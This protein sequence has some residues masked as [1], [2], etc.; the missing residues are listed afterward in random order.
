MAAKQKA[1]GTARGGLR[2]LEQMGLRD[3]E[4]L[5]LVLRGESVVD[6]RR[7][8]FETREQV[9]AFLAI[10]L[11]ELSNVRDEQRVRSILA[12]AV[13]YLRTVFGYRVASAVANPEDLRDL[14][15]FASGVLEPRKYRRIACVVL[16]VMHV[17]QHLEAREL[18][19]RTP[20]REVDL[21]EKVDRRVI[22]ELA[23]LQEEG[24]PI[25]EFG[26]SAKPHHSLM[27]KLLA[28]RESVAAQIFDR[29]R[30]RIVCE[31]HDQIPA[32]VL[33]LTERLFPF[34]HTIPGQTQ[35]N[36][37]SFAQVLR[38][39][40]AGAKLHDALQFQPEEGEADPSAPTNDFSG[41]G[42]RVLNFIVDL[43]IRVDE[44]LPRSVPASEDLGRIVYSL[45][46]FQVVDAET[47]RHNESGDSAHDR[48]KR[49]Q[50]KRVLRR[51]SRGLVV[52]KKG[53]PH[54]HGKPE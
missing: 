34:N 26:G 8:D 15:L 50:L 44:F 19:F 49:R 46:E 30:Y 23:R 7:L 14:F 38:Q 47:Q 32:V 4:T 36:L 10:N 51:L 43:P 13:D 45:V 25:V 6:W 20:V 33:K 31:R 2:P 11:L 41:K 17:V 1:E 5:R 12:Q 53:K 16:K 24:L 37:V 29:V 42:F 27:T 18:L 40:P 39:H 52:P 35:N 9:D 48:Y 28:K 21:A 3:L 54:G 22:D